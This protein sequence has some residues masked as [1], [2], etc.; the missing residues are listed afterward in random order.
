MKKQHEIE[1]EYARKM[2]K[3]PE[4]LIEEEQEVDKKLLEQQKK[5]YKDKENEQT[6]QYNDAEEKMNHNIYG[7]QLMQAGQLRTLEQIQQQ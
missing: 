1:L 6:V 3:S 2:I 4:Q 7:Y 5:E